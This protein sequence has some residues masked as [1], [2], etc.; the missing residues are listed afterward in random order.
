[1]VNII[2]ELQQIADLL[3]NG[4][5]RTRVLDVID[6]FPKEIH[7][8]RWRGKR[9][10]EWYTVGELHAMLKGIGQTTTEFGNAV[11][12]IITCLIP[13][14]PPEYREYATVCVNEVTRVLENLN[15][16]MQNPKVLLENI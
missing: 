4:V 8:Q 10:G 11:E 7:S 2:E 16:R 12:P 3:P 6:E 5:I 9:S 13:E 1:M 14:L 15:N